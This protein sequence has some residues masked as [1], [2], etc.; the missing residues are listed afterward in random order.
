MEQRGLKQTDLV[1]LFGTASIVS[2]VLSGKREINARHAR[3]LSNYFA[4]PA[5]L[6]V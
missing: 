4:L 1:G 6:F 3:E 2:E 5:D